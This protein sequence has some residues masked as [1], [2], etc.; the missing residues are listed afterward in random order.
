MKASSEAACTSRASA[1]I[2]VPIAANAAAATDDRDDPQVEAIPLDGREHGHDQQHQEGHGERA[3][4]REQALLGQQGRARHRPADEPAERVLVALQRERA[5]RQ[6]HGHEHQ[7]HGDCDSRGK[8]RERH[9]RAVDDLLVDAD[10]LAERG[11]HLARQ[12]EVRL[13]DAGEPHDPV[14]VA[15]LRRAARQPPARGLDRLADPAQAEHVEAFAEHG[16]V[17]AVQQQVQVAHV[18]ARERARDLAVRLR[19]RGRDRVV[20]EARLDRVLL[21]DDH[22]EPRLL[23]ARLDLAEGVLGDDQRAE[24]VAVAH[25]LLGLLARRDAHRLDVVAQLVARDPE[26]QRPRADVERLRRAAPR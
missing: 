8:G 5:G 17:A 9:A 1:P 16:H 13:R 14:E 15:A 6:Q 2:S 23:D 3:G 4:E 21:A 24:H 7:R 10:R 26:P 25:E 11:Q 18:R 22:L 12:P 19:E 20:D